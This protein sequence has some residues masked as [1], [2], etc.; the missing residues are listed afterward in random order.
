MAA[1]VAVVVSVAL[2]VGLMALSDRKR[3]TVL[4][5]VVLLAGGAVFFLSIAAGE[6]AGIGPRALAILAVGLLAA[7]AGGMLYHL[8][9]GRFTD[10][11]LARGVFAAVYLGLAAAFGL[12][13]L[14]LF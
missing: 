5:Q 10:L 12:L 8:Y 6:V 3:G 9:V 13:F 11:R 7:G 14:V 4:G 1:L 2:M